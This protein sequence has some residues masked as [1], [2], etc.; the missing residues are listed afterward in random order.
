MRKNK[1]KKKKRK[2]QSKLFIIYPIFFIKKINVPN[3]VVI[4]LVQ[5]FRYFTPTIEDEDIIFVRQGKSRRDL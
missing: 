2:I 3:F 1:K 5:K 4:T